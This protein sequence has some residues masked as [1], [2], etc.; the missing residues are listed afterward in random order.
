M[1]IDRQ[2]DGEIDDEAEKCAVA[3]NAAMEVAMDECSP[4]G[5][6]ATIGQMVGLDEPPDPDDVP[7]ELSKPDCMDIDIV[8]EWVVVRARQLAEDGE[9]LPDAIGMAWDEVSEDC[10]F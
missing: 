8:R 9:P 2:T 3:T 4:Q 6:M 7:T 1:N 5:L 10:G